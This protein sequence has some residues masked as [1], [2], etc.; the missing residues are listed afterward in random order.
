LFTLLVGLSLLKNGIQSS[1]L[2]KGRQHYFAAT[3]NAPVSPTSATN[4][5]LSSASSLSSQKPLLS[6]QELLKTQTTA[7]K[8]SRA[9]RLQSVLSTK[10]STRPS[11]SRSVTVTQFVSAIVRRHTVAFEINQ[12]QLV[13]VQPLWEEYKISRVWCEFLDVELEKDYLKWEVGGYAAGHKSRFQAESDGHQ[14]TSET[15]TV[16]DGF[17]SK[18]RTFCA[19]GS[20]FGCVMTFALY[21]TQD[22]GWF[23]H[24]FKFLVSFVINVLVKET[25]KC[26]N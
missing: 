21:F 15:A 6:S 24:A 7:T 8:K 3:G 19:M 10:P 25:V 12:S 2:I 23:Y 11:I 18:C 13:L 22:H 26:S 9:S 20:A 14:M 1:L 16:N 4:S 17:F 5:A